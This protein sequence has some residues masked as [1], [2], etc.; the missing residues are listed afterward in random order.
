VRA[1]S[2]RLTVLA[3]AGDTPGVRSVIDDLDVLP[4]AGVGA[5]PRGEGS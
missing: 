1:Q 2:E 5:P 3:I 4:A